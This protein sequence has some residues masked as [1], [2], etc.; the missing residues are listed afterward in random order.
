MNNHHSHGV[1]NNVMGGGGGGGGQHVN[2]M[3]ANG[4]MIVSQ[5]IQPSSTSGT[6]ITPST[7]PSASSSSSSPLSLSISSH[8]H[9]HHHQQ[10]QQSATT[11]TAV[12]NGA[13]VAATASVR[14][15]ELVRGFLTPPTSKQIG[16]KDNREP[17]V[18]H[19]LHI[20]TRRIP[21]M[22]HQSIPQMEVAAELVGY[23]KPM[24]MKD[25]VMLSPLQKQ[26]L[27]PQ[28]TSNNN[29]S[30]VTIDEVIVMKFS[31]LVV[32]H[33]SH[34]HGQKLLCRFNLTLP[35]GKVIDVAESAEFETITRRGIEK[36]RQKELIIKKKIEDE[37]NTLPPPHVLRVEPSTSLV[38]GGNLV[39]IHV[40]NLPSSIALG[41]GYPSVVGAL[42]TV[43]EDDTSRSTMSS[44]HSDQSS[45]SNHRGSFVSSGLVSVFFGKQESRE[46]FSARNDVIV[47]EVPPSLQGAVGEVVINVS[48]D[49]KKTFLS[50]QATLNYI[51]VDT[52]TH[53]VRS[54]SSVPQQH[55]QQQPQQQHGMNFLQTDH[56][57][58]ALSLFNQK[59]EPERG[60]LQ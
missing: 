15:M 37:N 32:K 7:P 13:T 5:S 4:H 19:V 59:V 33:S 28:S 20:Y 45:R 58:I 55:Y 51:T 56:A 44:P 22:Y 8:H 12:G 17:I 6:V 54:A 9:H 31:N 40:Q 29:R 21:S 36:Q 18:E 43:L 60:T 27:I 25:K 57:T 2:V 50:S 46:I 26:S 41:V 34:N 53:F 42:S 14:I 39:K 16:G 30:A 3:N 38:Q 23:K 48:L 52:L 35:N 47:C 49:G 1:M 24:L 10:Q 11:P